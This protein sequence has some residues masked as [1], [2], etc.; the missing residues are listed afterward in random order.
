MGAADRGEHRQAAGAVATP[1]VTSRQN[2]G[3]VAAHS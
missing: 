3:L 2:S 1:R